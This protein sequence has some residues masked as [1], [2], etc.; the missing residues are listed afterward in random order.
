[1]KNS[2]KCVVLLS[3]A[4]LIS[5]GSQQ[6]FRSRKYTKG[7]FRVANKRIKSSSPESKKEQALATID[8]EEQQI[9]REHLIQMN[10]QEESTLSMAEIVPLD[11]VHSST[12]IVDREE[13]QTNYSSSI[14]SVSEKHQRKPRSEIA[15]TTTQREKKNKKDLSVGQRQARSSLTWGIVAIS[16]AVALITLTLISGPSVFVS[17]ILYF[18][19]V[20]RSIRLALVPAV[21]G[22]VQSTLAKFGNEDLGKYEKHRKVGF[23]L[24]ISTLLLWALLV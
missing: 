5:C 11:E 16:L 9:E 4:F 20:G 8:L 1:M 18:F 15:E 22:I 21:I 2:L 19:L 10:L 23:W 24:C 12:Y 14:S 3:T 17:P 6:N 13:T 7:K